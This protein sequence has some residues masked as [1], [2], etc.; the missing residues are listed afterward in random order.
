MQIEILHIDDCSNWR[1]A[2]RL[3]SQALSELRITGAT[4]EF[5]RIS[6]P[7]QAATRRFA[8]SP[9]ILIDGVD[10]F[11]TEGATPDLACRVY[12]ADGRF[13]GTPGAAEIRAAIERTARSD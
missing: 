12:Q 11:P 7:E 1:E 2:G 5:T 13:A 8:G 6:T 10:P 3:V 9:T 4:V